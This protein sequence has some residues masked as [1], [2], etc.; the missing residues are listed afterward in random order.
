MNPAADTCRFVKTLPV[1]ALFLPSIINQ[2]E[3]GIDVA[4]G[5]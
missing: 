1:T 3:F 5:A 4:K 2:F